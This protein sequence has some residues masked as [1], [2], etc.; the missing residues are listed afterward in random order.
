MK[1]IDVSQ[2][3]LLKLKNNPYPGRGIVVG[4]SSDSRYLAHIYWIMG[5]SFN[6]Q[7][8]IF[9]LDEDG[10]LRT[11][12][13][14]QEKVEDPS[15]IIYKAMSRSSR[16]FAVSNGHQTDDALSTYVLGMEKALSSWKYEPDAPNFTPRITAV[17][18]LRGKRVNPVYMSVFSKSPL[19]NGCD[20]KF[21]SLNLNYPG[22]GYCVTT[23]IGDGNPLP[24]FSGD[25]YLLPITGNI[26]EAAFNI[27][28]NLNQD[29]R[30]SLA[31][32][33]INIKS[34]KSDFK[35]IN[36]HG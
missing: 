36:K 10:S 5:R 3:N 6:S 32:R 15:L 34:G 14:D 11:Q 17:S 21:Y 4:L 12:A 28:D 18:S 27:W 23:Y 33:F 31:V 13:F 25:P 16:Y 26:E 22:I 9:V 8:R 19:G 2:E 35:I 29:N 20:R 30:V 24:S 7:N 1:F